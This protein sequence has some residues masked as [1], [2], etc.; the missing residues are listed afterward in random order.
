[1]RTIGNISAKIILF[2]VG[3]SFQAQAV[4]VIDLE[5]KTKSEVN[6]DYFTIERSTD[7]MSW[8][9][10]A[11]VDGN[12]NTTRESIYTYSDYS[13]P[14]GIVYYCL[15]QTD[16]DGT[17]E[18]LRMIS[19]DN[20]RSSFASVIVYPNPA[21]ENLSF[22]S[23][24]SIQSATIINS[25]FQPVKT[26]DLT[27]NAINIVDLPSGVYYFKYTLADGASHLIPFMKK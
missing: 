18:T 13:A 25:S 14:D 16:F 7:G 20:S 11:T 19:I 26:I 22:Q 24:A 9:M 3:L 27:M 5:W 6:N 2:I 12:G 21:V 15:K 8:E 23:D 10:I 17:T 1:M 4:T